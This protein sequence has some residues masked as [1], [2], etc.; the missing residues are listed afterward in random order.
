MSE[1]FLFQCD[2]WRVIYLGIKLYINCF[3]SS[4]EN[5]SFLICFHWWKVHD[6][7]TYLSFV[8]K[9][10]N[11]SF[12]SRKFFHLLF[13]NFTVMYLAISL[14]LFMLLST[15]SVFSV[16]GLLFPQFWNFLNFYLF[17]YYFSAKPM[18]SFVWYSGISYIN[19]LVPPIYYPATLLSSFT[20]DLS[21]L[22]SAK[23]FSTVF[24]IGY[25]LL[26]SWIFLKKLD[27]A[28][29]KIASKK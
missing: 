2:S 8:K 12:L 6:Q 19:T 11:P 16:W 4:F 26:I 21:L 22:C 29:Y 13:C 1:I 27:F 20:L 7:P 28:L 5:V 3:P 17:K 23:L 9:K 18:V 14:F 15:C 24:R 25:S 10:K